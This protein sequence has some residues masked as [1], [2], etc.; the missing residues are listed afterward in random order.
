MPITKSDVLSLIQ[1]AEERNL[2]IERSEDKEVVN[3]PLSY[4][5]PSTI[6]T[7]VSPCCEGSIITTPVLPTWIN[8]SAIISP[9]SESLFV[10]IVAISFILSSTGTDTL[11]KYAI[12]LFT[13]DKIPS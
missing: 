10:D 9:S 3:N 5:T 2:L 6:S 12:T 1:D 7:L 13:A 8:A 4:S 11:F